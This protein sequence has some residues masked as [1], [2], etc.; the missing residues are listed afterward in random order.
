MLQFRSI[1]E[2]GAGAAASVCLVR[3]GAEI[4][5]VQF[6]HGSFY[7]DEGRAL[8]MVPIVSIPDGGGNRFCRFKVRDNNNFVHIHSDLQPTCLLFHGV[9]F[10]SLFMCSCPECCTMSLHA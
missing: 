5:F 6:Y 9:L 8:F 2:T 7:T 4:S 1:F 10:Q 3:C